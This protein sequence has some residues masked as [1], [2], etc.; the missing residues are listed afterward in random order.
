MC[1]KRACEYLE[2][3]R[4]PPIDINAFFLLKQS[5][6]REKAWILAKEG[7]KEDAKQLCV[8]CIEAL[9]QRFGTVFCFWEFYDVLEEILVL[10]KK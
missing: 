7:K 3:Y 2:H 1:L 6:A 9:E 10:E 4:V 5:I 8:S